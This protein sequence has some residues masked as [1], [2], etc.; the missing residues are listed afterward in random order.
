MSAGS[1]TQHY[2]VFHPAIRFLICRLS[3]RTS[4]RFQQT[5]VLPAWQYGDSALPSAIARACPIYARRQFSLPRQMA[6]YSERHRLSHTEFFLASSDHSPR[7]RVESTLETFVELSPCMT[8][9]ICAVRT[10]K[11]LYQVRT[12]YGNRLPVFGRVLCSQGFCFDVSV[13]GSG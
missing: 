11:G 5:I 10:R 2:S 9:F 3:S 6:D 8:R 7:E 4:Q 12:G 13:L 1:A